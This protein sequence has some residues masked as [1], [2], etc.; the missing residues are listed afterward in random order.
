MFIY[1]PQEEGGYPL[2]GA[3]RLWLHKSLERLGRDLRERFGSQLV[4]RHAEGSCSSAET[5]LG[6]MRE[7][8]AETV[9]FNRVYE[10]WKLERDARVES[11]VDAA[12]GTCQSF[13]AGVLY[14]PWDA[15]PDE[16]DESCWNGGYG[17]VGFFLRAIDRLG[18]PPEP[19]AAP[20]KL[21]APAAWPRSEPLS[22]LRL[23]TI[24]RNKTTGKPVDWCARGPTRADYALSPT[25]CW[26]DPPLS[27]R[28]PPR[29]RTTGICQSW[30]FGEAAAHEALERFAVESGALLQFD[31]KGVQARARASA[32]AAPPSLASA[33][34]AQCNMC[35]ER[36]RSSRLRRRTFPAP[37]VSGE[38]ATANRFRADVPGTARISPY[39]RFGELSPRQVYARCLEAA[40]GAGKAGA[41]SARVFLRRLAWRDLFYWALWR[42]PKI[43]WEP[44][45]PQYDHQWWDHPWDHKRDDP[46]T[47]LGP[48][49]ARRRWEPP[50]AGL[51]AWQR[52]ETGYPLVR[53]ERLLG[54]GGWLVNLFPRRGHAKRGLAAGHTGAS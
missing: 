18:P 54:S 36:L 45:R 15:R 35:G 38:H 4:L 50:H 46:E 20:T 29:L 30:G 2:G 11:A 10:P 26:P 40:G 3:A 14:E 5:L 53:S 24:P 39:L 47:A 49:A 23:V 41:R 25:R 13:C 44:L 6:L 43:P 37:Q 22:A 7:T 28:V 17:S 8:G 48:A 27:A 42:F 1:A 9:V 51:K 19:V 21:R 12:G 16:K 52:G 34:K 32:A 31:S 33:T